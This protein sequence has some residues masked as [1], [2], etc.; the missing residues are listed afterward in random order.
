MQ[1]YLLSSKLLPESTFAVIF[2]R[3]TS[4]Q[5]NRDKIWLKN[6]SIVDVACGDSHIAIVSNGGKLYTFGANEWGQLGHGHTKT[7]SKPTQV[8]SKTI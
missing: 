4:L 3:V 7:L 1:I 5:E 6:D 2:G 8:K